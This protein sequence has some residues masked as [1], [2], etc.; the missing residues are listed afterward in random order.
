MQ[1]DVRFLRSDNYIATAC[2]HETGSQRIII[3]VVSRLL[4]RVPFW[5]SAGRNG[6]QFAAC[7]VVYTRWYV[8]RIYPFSSL[9]K[10]LR[11]AYPE[12]AYT[13]LPSAVSLQLENV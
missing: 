4:V 7:N 12:E 11:K 5:Y 8:R 1:I 13:F 10:A 9:G 2:G 3:D 6:R